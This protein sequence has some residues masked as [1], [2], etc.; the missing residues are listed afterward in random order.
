MGF[1][2]ELP[3]SIK[4]ELLHLPHV[5][6]VHV[7]IEPC[8]QQHSLVA[9]NVSVTRRRSININCNH[10]ASDGTK[11][12]GKKRNRKDEQFWLGEKESFIHNNF[13]LC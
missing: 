2:K 13:I 6:F 11:E 1:E 7:L 8:P 10:T 4:N 9:E 5:V 12:T 3:L